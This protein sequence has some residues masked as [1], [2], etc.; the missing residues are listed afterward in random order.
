MMTSQAK[1]GFHAASL[2]GQE[3]G[4][5]NV[6]VGAYMNRLGLGYGAIGWATDAAP[7]DT[8]AGSCP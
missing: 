4:R 8:W 5:G 3:K 1:I 2:G 7:D 6:L